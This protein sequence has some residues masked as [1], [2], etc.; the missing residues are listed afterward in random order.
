MD[1]VA[2]IDPFALVARSALGT[3]VIANDV[4]VAWVSVVVARVVVPEKMVEPVKVFVPEKVLASPRSV[5]EAAVMV[6][7]PP[8]FKVEPFTVP[9][10]PER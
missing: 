9:S 8:A 4:A 1:V 3:L 10:A 7:V 2:M 6:M 5:E